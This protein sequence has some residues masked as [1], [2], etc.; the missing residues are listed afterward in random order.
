M[1]LVNGGALLDY[2]T[3]DGTTAVHRAVERNNFEAVKTLLDLGA[4][5]NYKDARGLTPLYLAMTPNTD[6]ML[7]EALLHDHA[8]IGAQD[9]QGW[10]EVHQV[11]INLITHLYKISCKAF[12]VKLSNNS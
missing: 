7:C 2:R 11:R 10:Q 1:A 5:P 3:R 9:T 8:T 6:P 4:S 12:R